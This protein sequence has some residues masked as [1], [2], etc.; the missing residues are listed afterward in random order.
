ML[1]KTWF[2]AKNFG[3]KS[4]VI[5]AIVNRVVSF[6]IGSKKRFEEGMRCGLYDW[7][8]AGGGMA[9]GWK[10]EREWNA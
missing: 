4:A 3:G 5:V 8:F 1:H 9:V 10:V 7:V 6:E 2:F